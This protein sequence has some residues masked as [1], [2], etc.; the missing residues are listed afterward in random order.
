MTSGLTSTFTFITSVASAKEEDSIVSNE[1]Q[2]VDPWETMNDA[3]QQQGWPN[4]ASPLPIPSG[5]RSQSTG[6]GSRTN[7]T[8]TDASDLEAAF[9]QASKKKQVDPRT[10]G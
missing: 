9:Q 8:K 7:E 1:S 5:S 3:I 10:H 4:S 2:T 6:S